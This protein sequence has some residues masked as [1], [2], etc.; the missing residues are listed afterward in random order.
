MRTYRTAQDLGEHETNELTAEQLIVLLHRKLN[1]T[2]K[3][4][5]VHNAI[6]Y[7]LGRCTAHTMGIRSIGAE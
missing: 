7:I 5:R 6:V 1:H 3:D 2:E 4:S